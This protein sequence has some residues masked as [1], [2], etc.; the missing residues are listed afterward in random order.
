MIVRAYAEIRY[1]ISRRFLPRRFSNP[2]PSPRCIWSL[3]PSATLANIVRVAAYGGKDC[4]CE[5]RA[6]IDAGVV[7]PCMGRIPRLSPLAYSI[8]GR[9]QSRRIQMSS[10]DELK[11]TIRRNKLLGLWAAEKLG[12]TGP[13]A[14]AYA[15]A[16]AVGTLDPEL[17]DVFSRIRK[18]FDAAGVAQ[19]DE[20]ILRVMNEL[21]LQAAN[22]IPARRAGTPDAAAVMLAR[23][24]KPR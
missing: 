20:Q 7:L 19:S 9:R 15:D 14:E 17:S 4:G 10:L 21:M 5:C 24:L 8:T 23:N 6:V 13:D 2:R 12:R 16:L 18:D 3:D 11:T 22:Q 1:S